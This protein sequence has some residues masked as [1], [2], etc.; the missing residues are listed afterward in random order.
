MRGSDSRLQSSETNDSA[1]GAPSATGSGGD[2]V[3]LG[4][5]F[6]QAFRLCGPDTGAD[7]PAVQTCASCPSRAVTRPEWGATSKPARWTT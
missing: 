3:S 1:S 6:I 5:A 7:I 4:S 2:E